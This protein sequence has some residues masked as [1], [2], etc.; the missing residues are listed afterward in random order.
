MDQDLERTCQMLAL[1]HAIIKVV[2]PELEEFLNRYTV[3]AVK[4][5]I[6]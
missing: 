3:E 1:L 5:S 4:I 2:D 6:F